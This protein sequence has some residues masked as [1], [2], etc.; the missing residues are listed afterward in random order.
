MKRHTHLARLRKAINSCHRR[1][2]EFLNISTDT[3]IKAE[4]RQRSL[5]TSALV[6]LSPLSVAFESV[7]RES[8][9]PFGMLNCNE[10]VLKNHVRHLKSRLVHIKKERERLS[11]SLRYIKENW[12]AGSAHLNHLLSVKM[13][14]P[15]NDACVDL[16]NEGIE[17]LQARLRI[18]S[19]DQQRFLEHYIDL[20][21][22]QEKCLEE[23]L[24]G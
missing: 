19:P 7:E 12:R 21:T 6:K 14:V 22:D 23:M 15:E 11:H 20:L 18:F 2:A 4:V 1:M 10:L 17:K 13:R 24:A 5:T 9:F 3:Y 16:L 8:G